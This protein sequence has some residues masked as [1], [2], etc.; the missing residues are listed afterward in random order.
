[1]GLFSSAKDN[2]GHDET[3]ARGKTTSHDRKTAKAA[4]KLNS[5]IGKGSSKLGG[6][7]SRGKPSPDGNVER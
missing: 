7:S 5:K 1:V 4:H 6:K 2:H 3:H